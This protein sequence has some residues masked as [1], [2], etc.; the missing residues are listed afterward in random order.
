[1]RTLEIRLTVFIGFV[2]TA[3]TECVNNRNA[4]SEFEDAVSVVLQIKLQHTYNVKV[5]SCVTI[6]LASYVLQT[7]SLVLKL[8]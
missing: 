8:K 5:T 2:I 4:C 1:M 7:R 6:S 3:R